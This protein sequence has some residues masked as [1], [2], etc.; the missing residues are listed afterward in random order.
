[1]DQSAISRLHPT[2]MY[3]RSA[4][5][6]ARCLPIP[7]RV[8]V[9]SATGLSDVSGGGLLMHQGQDVVGQRF[10]AAKRAASLGHCPVVGKGE[11]D[12]VALVELL[13]DIEQQI[14]KTQ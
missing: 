7:L 8:P 3:P 2:T 12:A 4:R 13:F 10:Y 1:M 14:H 5:C 9:I 11:R 6:S